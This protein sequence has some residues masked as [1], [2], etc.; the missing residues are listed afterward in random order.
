MAQRATPTRNRLARK[1]MFGVGGALLLLGVLHLGVVVISALNHNQNLLEQRISSIADSLAYSMQTDESEGRLDRLQRIVETQSLLGDVVTIAVLDRDGQIVAHSDPRKQGSAFPLEM[2]P[3]LRSHVENSLHTEGLLTVRGKVDGRTLMAGVSELHS[4]M[5]ARQGGQGVSIVM[6]DLTMLIHSLRMSFVRLLLVECCGLLMVW[7][8]TLF[9]LRRHVA[10]PLGKLTQAALTSART[11]EFRGG[12]LKTGDELEVLAETLSGM[13]G[14][15]RETRTQA[16][17]LALVASRTDNAVAITDAQHRFEW[18]NQAFERMTEYT[19]AEVVGKTPA[20]LLQGPNSD[21][22]IIAHMRE[23][24]SQGK[25]FNVEII[26]YT[27]SAKEYWVAI[28]VQPI[29]D[30]TGRLTNY[31]AIE[32][33]ITERKWA[34]TALRGSQARINAVL[35]NAADG[36]VTLNARGRVEYFNASAARIFGFSMSE[37]LGRDFKTLIAPEERETCP[38]PSEFAQ[39][40]NGGGRAVERE[41][42]GLRKDGAIFPMTFKMSEVALDRSNIYIIVVQDTTDLK[43]KEDELRAALAEAEQAAV[44]KSE[45]LANMS[46]EIRTPMNGVI[47]MTALLLETPL[48]PEQRDFAQT[49]H[50]SAEALLRIVNDILDF[51]KVDAGKLELESIDF[52]LVRVLDEVVEM[53]A[54]NAHARKLELLGVV[55]PGTPTALRGDPGRL[56][57]ILI[58][59]CTN[60]IKFT[61]A[62]E[63]VITAQLEA[64]EPGATMIMFSVRDTGIGI[65]AERV[66]RLFK[67]FSQVDA[68]TTRQYGGTGLGLAICRSLTDLMGGEIGVESAPEQGST[69]WFTACFAEASAAQAE[70]AHPARG[71]RVLIVDDNAAT[72]EAIDGYLA[73]AGFEAVAAGGAYA[74]LTLLTEAAEAGRPFDLALIDREMPEINGT[75]LIAKMIQ[76]TALRGTRRVLMTTQEKGQGLNGEQTAGV[77]GVLNKPIRRGQLLTCMDSAMAA[78]PVIEAIPSGAAAG[79]TEVPAEA[80]AAEQG[81]GQ[82]R[83]LLVE[84]NSVNRKVALRLLATMG[85]HAE[86][87]VNGAEGVKALA[88]H[89]YDLVL[90]DVQMPVMDGYEATREIRRLQGDK[91]HTPIVAMTANAM[92]GDREKCLNAGMDDYISKPVRRDDLREMIERWLARAAV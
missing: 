77:S 57:Q 25:G 91:R 35:Q 36:I 47:G 18:V 71:G 32:S 46:H 23:R 4:T 64:S 68:S 62:G 19:L 44:A 53:L 26:N 58:N 49:V 42:H 41:M 11:G 86:S 24:L 17:K 9:L 48:E 38:S 59:L 63:V 1:L 37:V 34:E 90:M 83:I 13:F 52:D 88:E 56:R 22:R 51:S 10:D 14:Q 65:P 69:F 82:A 21:P 40:E 29:F 72:R 33:D 76:D 20:R 66:G 89:G 85:Y 84:D 80:A 54:H 61:H 70:E 75:D 60:A 16:E 79:G 6:L 78:L 28:E 15:L 2:M 5:F 12:E 43:R 67:P 31:M 3:G 81:A 92:K 74:A 50:S 8:V 39:T 73:D 27:K 30:E 45:F 7:F 87:A 55:R